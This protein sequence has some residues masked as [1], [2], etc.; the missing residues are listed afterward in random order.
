MSVFYESTY[1]DT[2][3]KPSEKVKNREREILLCLVG[4]CGRGVRDEF[5]TCIDISQ[6]SDSLLLG[7]FT[8][9]KWF[10]PFD[11][12]RTID[13]FLSWT[14]F[15]IKLKSCGILLLQGIRI[16]ISHNILF[17]FAQESWIK[18]L[19]TWH[20]KTHGYWLNRPESWPRE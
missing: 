16:H 5:K 15:T 10:E 4:V 1:D 20:G 7:T 19:C 14:R 18:N 12:D 17:I 11:R 3:S 8:Q 9:L 13:Y 6:N 2:S